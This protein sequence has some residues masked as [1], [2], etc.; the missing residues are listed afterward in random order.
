MNRERLS[1]HDFLS[2]LNVDSGREGVDFIGGRCGEHLD[3]LEVIDVGV[4]NGV[5]FDADDSRFGIGNFNVGIL[6]YTEK[7]VAF[8]ILCYRSTVYAYS[9][10]LSCRGL[11]L[12]A[13]AGENILGCGEVCY[14][15][16]GVFHDLG[17]GI[18]L[19]GEGYGRTGGVR[20]SSSERFCPRLR[21]AQ[22][23]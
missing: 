19:N 23:G 14:G 6:V 4:F 16:N 22:T 2:F 17:F 7:I 18:A 12:E 10:I 21:E 1:Y 5:A 20:Q 15:N 8:V 13:G 3:A 11:N 9:Q